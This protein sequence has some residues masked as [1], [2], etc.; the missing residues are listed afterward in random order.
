MISANIEQDS[1][2]SSI[3]VDHEYLFALLIDSK[4]NVIFKFAVL[5]FDNG[6]ETA[7]PQLSAMV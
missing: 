3:L 7:T 4:N 1:L 2:E 6:F 5:Y